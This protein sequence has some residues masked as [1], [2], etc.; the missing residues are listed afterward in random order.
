MAHRVG[1]VNPKL[2]P[3]SQSPGFDQPVTLYELS[4]GLEDS[5]PFDHLIRA[6]DG[7]VF[8]SDSRLSQRLSNLSAMKVLRSEVE[9][10]GGA[11]RLGTD[12]TDLVIPGKPIILQHNKRDLPD[13]MTLEEMESELNWRNFA[14]F[15]S[16]ATEGVGVFATLVAV[17]RLAAMTASTSTTGGQSSN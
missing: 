15:D 12:P 7:I 13:C 14:S 17:V 4:G 16:V 2:K 5:Q 3:L 1:I 11:L 6:V 9:R 10:Q 8:V